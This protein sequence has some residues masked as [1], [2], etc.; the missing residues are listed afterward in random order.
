ML[1][2]NN[3]V[4]K[5]ISLSDQVEQ[6]DISLS[7]LSKLVDTQIYQYRKHPNGFIGHRESFKLKFPND[8]G[9]KEWEDAEL[10]QGQTW[11]YLIRV[12]KI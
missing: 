7:E 1:K 11:M 8:D 10:L 4:E 2:W 6:K 5:D 9:E 12:E 3:Q